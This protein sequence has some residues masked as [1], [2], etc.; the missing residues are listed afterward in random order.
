MITELLLLLTNGHVINKNK[1]NLINIE[2]SIT[3][4]FKKVFIIKQV[5]N[6]PKTGN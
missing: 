2:F 1:K 4:K 5:I 3:Q 6:S